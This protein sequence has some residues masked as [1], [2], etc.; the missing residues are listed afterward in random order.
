MQRIMLPPTI[1]GAPQPLPDSR[2]ITLVGANGAGKSLFM[3]EMIRRSP[4]KA[5]VLSALS[6]SF[7]E[8]RESSLPGSIDSLYTE[9]VRQMPYLR[10][11]AVSEIDKLSF[12]LFSDEFEYLL[13]IKADGL[14]YGKKVALEPTRL[15]RVRSLWERIFPGNHIL[16]HTG[17]LMFATDSGEDLIP[18]RGLSQGEQ[19]VLYYIAA[20]LYAMP[21]AVIFVDSPSLFM[22]PAILN[23]V[24]NGI[25]E[26]RPDCTFVYD[27]TDVDFVNSRTQNATIWVRSY[28]AAARAWDYNVFSPGELSD[29]LFI[30]L[31]G[32]RKPVLFIEGDA[33]HSIDAK[34]YTLVFSDYTVRPLGS[35]NKVI[36]TTRAFNDLKPMHH[37]D[38]HGLVDRDRRDT[39]EVDYLRRKNIF[40]PDVAEVENIFLLE[41]VVRV[42]AR[43]RG[44]DPDKIMAK[45]RKQVMQMFRTHFDEQALQHV[46]HR[47]KHDVECKI[48]ARFKC[49]SAME[50][51]L[52]TL[53]DKLRPR[54]QYNT[55]RREFQEMIRTDDYNGVL[56]VFNHKPM[57]PESNVAGLL[58]FPNKETYISE[59]LGVLKGTGKDARALKA[60]IKFC[61]RLD[62]ENNPIDP[63][64]HP[65][66]Q[67]LP[68]PTDIPEQERIERGRRQSRRQGKRYHRGKKL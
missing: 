38:S 34:L 2:Q 24:W 66:P 52:R 12:L 10:G 1:D 11:D 56:R 50:L 17:K 19:A 6:A 26:L 59:V 36:E 41:E 51:H 31:M 63:T 18:A 8:K 53:I 16:R 5:Y 35:C 30:D 58:G 47:V 43:R 15:D 45:L 46:R 33:V 13:G 28:D 23:T 27:T 62:M 40:V 14:R 21:G 39:E 44:K 25:E 7:P 29:D 68:A 20:T 3:E 55:L 64:L 9:A 22:H 60:A 67:S 61:F 48:D 65:T 32:S 37:L 4:G 42:M 57:L 54:E 49:I